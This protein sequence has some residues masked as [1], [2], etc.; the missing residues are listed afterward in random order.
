MGHII[1]FAWSLPVL[2]R[3]SLPQRNDTFALAAAWGREVHG[4]PSLPACLRGTECCLLYPNMNPATSGRKELNIT[5]VTPSFSYFKILISSFHLLTYS[6]AAFCSSG[7]CSVVYFLNSREEQSR[8]GASLRWSARSLW[9]LFPQTS[10]GA[11]DLAD[12]ASRQSGCLSLW[13]SVWGSSLAL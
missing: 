1:C 6:V 5:L 11:Q 8:W 2:L 12:A 13:E 4:C 9:D 10:L 3:V 7:F